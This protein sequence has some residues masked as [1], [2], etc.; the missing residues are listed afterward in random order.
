MVGHSDRARRGSGPVN[1]LAAVTAT[2]ALCLLGLQS[3]AVA[4]GSAHPAGHA[5]AGDPHAGKVQAGHAKPRKRSDV[6]AQCGY[7]KAGHARCFALVRTDDKSGK[8]VLPNATTPNG[9]GPSDLSSA[10]Q[11]P[12]NGGAGLT[13]AI[14]DAFDNPNAEADL[15]IYRAQYG[16]PECSTAN[17]CFTKVNQRGEQ[18]NYPPYDPGWAGEIALDLD[19]VSAAAPNA[20]ILL[21]EG[22]DA[23]FDAL[24]A[25]VDEAV[26]LGAKVVSNSYGS[27][28]EDP[29]EV[30]YNASYD[31]PGVAVTASTGDSGYYG[32]GNGTSFP[33]N[34][35][36]VVAVGGTSLVPDSSTRGWSET[37][38]N[39][40]YGAPGSGCSLYQTKPAW[41]TDPGC[42]NRTI[43]DVSAVAD[44]ATGVAVYNTGDGGWVVY[45]GTSVSA[46]LVAGMYA[47][48]GGPVTGTE[49]ASYPYAKPGSFNDVTVG[50]DGAPCS[51]SYL[52]TAGA[53]YD[54]PTGLGTP[55][56][57]TG[58]QT[59]PHG[60]V[61]GTVTDSGTGNPI[62]GATVTA[63][64][65][66][67]ITATN[68]TYSMSVPVGTYDVKVTAFGYAS[69]TRTGVVVTD[70]GTVTEDFALDSVPSSTVSGVVRD[71]SGHN[72]PLYAQ[73]TVAG[74][75]NAPVWTNPYTGAYQVDL[76]QGSSYDLSVK[77]Y[78]PGYLPQQLSV[79]VGTSDQILNI[80]MPIDMT[81]VTAPGYSVLQA[82]T[83]ETFDDTTGPP[84][85]WTVDN[86]TGT[87][88]WV[89]DDPAGRG[90][91]TGGQGNFAIVDSDYD[92]PDAT[93]DTTLTSPSYDL[94]GADT[95]NLQFKTD[96]VPFIDTSTATVQLSTDGGTSWSDVWS[97]TTS[98]I[99]PDATIDVA[100][101][102]AANQPDVQV[103]FHYTG[104]YS[105]YWEVDDVVV[106]NRTVVIDHGGLVAGQVRSTL[107]HT[108]LVAADVSSVSA[109][110]DHGSS[111]AT[112]DDPDVG[113][114]FY[115]LFSSL[116]GKHDFRAVKAGYRSTRETVNVITNAVTQA[117]FGLAS[118]RFA[119]TPKTISRTVPWRGTSTATLTV[120]NTGNALATVKVSEQSG[121]FTIL[122]RHGAALNRT[123]AKV[124]MHRAYVKGATHTAAPRTA[125]PFDAPWTSIADYPNAIQDNAADFSGGKLYSAFGF[126]GNADT[127]DGYV[128]DPNFGSWSAIASAS[129]TRETPAHGFINGKWYIAGGWGADG[130]P[131][132]TS[133]VY[134]PAADSWGS[135][136]D[137]PAPYAGSGSAVL[138]GKLY[139]VGGCG[140]SSCGT[141]DV[142]S[143]DPASDSWNQAADYPEP[144]SWE[145]CGAISSK[146]Y[147]GGGVTDNGSI[148]HAYVYDPSSDTWAPIADMPVDQ[149][150]ASYTAANNLLLVSGG[151]VQ[152]SSVITNEGSS[153]NPATNQWS[154]LPNSNQTTYRGAGALGF[155]RVGG[156]PGGFSS[157]VTTAE[158]L[159]G[160][161]QGGSTNVKWLSETPTT[162]TLAPGA[163]RTITVTISAKTPSISQPGTYTASLVYETNTPYSVRATSVAMKVLA[164]KTWGKVTGVVKGT[165][166]PQRILPGATVAVNGKH[167]SWTLKT[168]THG[169]YALWLSDANNPVRLIVAK[170]GYRPATKLVTIKR[171]RTLTVNWLLTK[172]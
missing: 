150:G 132:A 59:G 21:V 53:G 16:L 127:S 47:T 91:L 89:F 33:A 20:H 76:P 162:L 67:A 1:R 30:G 28:G 57:I 86:G 5:Q 97:A 24:A 36:H 145:A 87:T 14:V 64:D 71:G 113:D 165:G 115:W 8:G 6:K 38:W 46:P 74:S 124:S 93:Q 170:D 133:E 37:V 164:P 81:N 129:D 41:Q 101:P 105:Y 98:P 35:P 75:P 29:A 109:P 32:D 157:P 56:G 39:N 161:N 151:A 73:I 72:W 100:L 103:R 63:G 102:A 27:G 110:A 139:V 137:S 92:G 149:W 78:Y 18:G 152:D 138:N 10:Y 125:S 94:S 7:P 83:P 155:Y 60:T 107:T 106:G 153:Y 26:T 114:G 168:D 31:H 159:P 171:G 142:Y 96:Y 23:T 140:A 104:A 80:D 62:A 172:L 68:G 19:M 2:L 141:T 135:V 52:C 45:G 95:P 120:Q 50:D 43:S 79:D 130:N 163:S 166:P 146:L 58:L 167:G 158:V 65:A 34:N 13:I 9:Y 118:G 51:P 4:A 88:G 147:C 49:P 121:S 112:P 136:A 69:Q 126:D 48:A 128:F 131:D 148:T 15:A 66:S 55:A 61:T 40:A 12:A 123:P 11:I 85:G 116:T 84:P 117:N 17:G 108:P 90:N 119:V 156:S 44:P 25:S 154:A 134:D 82:G 77:A 143:Y 144:V 70:G 169:R 111:A 99:G 122:K 3:T 54:G 42:A 160:F 22:D